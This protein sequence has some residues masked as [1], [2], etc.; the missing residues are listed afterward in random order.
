[1]RRRAASGAFA[2]VFACALIA[3]APGARAQSLDLPEELRTIESVQYKGLR[4]LSRRKLV[5]GTSLRTRR[6]SVFPWRER[7]TLRRDYLRADSS[8]IVG[9]YRHYGYLR[10]TVRVR[11]LPAHDARSTRVVFEVS[12]GPRTR[13]ERVELHDVTAYP[14]HEL[15]RSLLS[16]PRVPFDPAFLQLDTLR[17]KSL[18]RE[19][20]YFV[21]VRDTAR[22]GSDSVHVVV[23]FDVD[24]GPLYRVGTVE[25]DSS[26]R[27]RQSLGR[28]ELLMRTGDIYRETRLQRTVERLYG[29][30]LYRQV[31]VSSVLDSASH[32]VDLRFRLSDRKSRWIDGGVG[33]GTTDRFRVSGQWGHR[34]LDTRALSGAVNG[35]YSLDGSAHFH[36]AGAGATLTEPWLLG[37]RLLGQSGVY[38]L[39]EDD[40]SNTNFVR[41]RDERGVTFTLFRE[42]SRLS[43]ATLVQENRFIHQSYDTLPGGVVERP[44]TLLYRYR[45]NTLRLTLERDLRDNRISPTRGSY[46]IVS[47][48]LAGGVLKGTTSYRKSVVSSVWYSPLSNGWSLAT[49]ATA[50]LMSPFGS[51][52]DNFSPTEG[53]DDQVARVPY[54]S[55]F[56]L[57][58]VNSLRG[59]GENSL[60][61]LGGLAMGLANLEVRIPVAGPFGIEAFVDAGNVWPRAEYLRAGDL[62]PPWQAVRTRANDLRWSYGLG[63]RLVLP[64]GPLRM[65]I[66]WSDRTDFPTS[67]LGKNLMP[68]VYQFAIGPSF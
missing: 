27:V 4:A 47:G 37:V 44:D 10:T 3:G 65:D 60:P 38:Y 17:I 59:W 45:T 66:A 36:K 40:R 67:K 11:L 61:P 18:Y 33:S 30:G 8:S 24:E 56:F 64:F 28:R 41:H 26:T 7:P 35:E 13:I 46:Q 1:L 5:K 43:R 22:A 31:Q 63:A 34:N 62:V 23:S 15:L 32:A 20:G 53:L 49:R 68:F 21:G 16:R 14:P 2:L 19:R 9:L 12:E 58:G 6:P 51:T 52:P 25:F 55:R 50:G 29:T 42:L 39:R 57:G 48:E 54:E